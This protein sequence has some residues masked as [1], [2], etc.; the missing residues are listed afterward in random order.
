MVVICIIN[1]VKTCVMFSVWYTRLRDAHKAT[2][3]QRS[4][5]DA[6][7]YTLGD[8]IASYMR[9][10]DKSTIAMCL[11]T[12]HDFKRK[13]DMKFRSRLVMKPVTEPREW[14]PRS[15]FWKSAASL[16]RWIVLLFL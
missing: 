14:E 8:A 5:D 15:M 2:I 4:K 7:L 16:N 1:T 12:R 11:A 9:D 6:V 3:A 13:R 10:P